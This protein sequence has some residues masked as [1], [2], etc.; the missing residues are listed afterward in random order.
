MEPVRNPDNSEW[1]VRVSVQ[2]LAYSITWDKSVKCS[3]FLR[4]KAWLPHLFG[5][6]RNNTCIT[7]GVLEW[8]VP[9]SCW[10]FLKF[11]QLT[12]WKSI[13]TDR[14]TDLSCKY[15]A[16]R[17]QWKHLRLE[18]LVIY[19]KSY[20]CISWMF[21]LNAYPVVIL[22]YML[23]LPICAFILTHFGLYQL[24]YAGGFS[25]GSSPGTLVVWHYLS[26]A[27]VKRKKYSHWPVVSE[28]VTW[29]SDSDTVRD[30]W[31]PALDIT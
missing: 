26:S 7:F 19:I 17:G 11:P 21:T 1:L 6:I 18:V 2:V 29:D 31:G 4:W 12:L 3:L 8:K 14:V 24:V 25:W 27:G 16:N 20:P 15:T 9:W 22:V 23:N 28:F 30:P 5:I 10:L 13:V